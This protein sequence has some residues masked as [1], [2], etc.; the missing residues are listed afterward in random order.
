MNPIHQLLTHVRAGIGYILFNFKFPSLAVL[1]LAFCCIIL[2][3]GLIS[4]ARLV[5][6]CKFPNSYVSSSVV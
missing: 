3:K 1:C 2:H 6:D 5:R 4:G